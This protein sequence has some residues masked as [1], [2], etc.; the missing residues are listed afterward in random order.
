V[1]LGL[2]G[3]TA[4]LLHRS[5]VLLLPALVAAPLLAEARTSKRSAARWAA[6]ALPA[7]AFL[8]MAPRVAHILATIDPMHLTPDEVRRRGLL[9]ATFAGAR[10]LDMVN[11]AVLL[12]PLA[13]PALGAAA[14]LLA[15][16][17]RR[18]LSRRE[19]LIVT[20]LVVPAVASTPFVHP[21]QGYWRDWDDFAVMGAALAVASA[22]LAAGLLGAA[23]RW[24]WLAVPVTLCAAMPTLQW[25]IHHRELDHGLARVR[26]FL[27]EPPPR[28]DMERY[29]Q[30]QFLG[31]RAVERERYREAAEAYEGAAA[32]IPSPSI[33]RQWAIAR[34]EGGD[35]DGARTVYRTIVT[36]NPDDVTGWMGLAATSS[37]LGDREGAIRA[38]QE[39]LRLNPDDLETR[40]TLERLQRGQASR[41]AAR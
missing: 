16:P 17:G 21:G 2:A 28:P 35:L 41:P 32:V 40:R 22:W 23:R 9:A 36:R 25:L 4:A 18:A 37:R 19:A 10:P 20:A 29:T 26:A 30:W 11:L 13:I 34:S 33:L 15:G 7:V 6:L 12:A 5:A 39:L 24:A 8:A 3:A 14:A 31:L 27:V 38:L 1:V